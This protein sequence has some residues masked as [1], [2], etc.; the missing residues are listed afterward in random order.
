M[1]DIGRT[2]INAMK[3]A[4]YELKVAISI[5]ITIREKVI[6]E[7][8]PM[9]EREIGKN[10]KKF[11]IPQYPDENEKRQIVN[12]LFQ[13]PYALAEEEIISFVENKDTAKNIYENLKLLLQES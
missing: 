4:E 8:Y 9:I 12:F 3:N 13:I 6:Y 1:D 10:R 11:L 2:F 5:F 7:L